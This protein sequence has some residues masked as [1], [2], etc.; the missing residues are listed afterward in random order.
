MK[1]T[2]GMMKCTEDTNLEIIY[3]G[4]IVCKNLI[5]LHTYLSIKTIGKLETIELQ[6]VNLF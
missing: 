1:D 5:K 3:S 2:A 6:I 4:L